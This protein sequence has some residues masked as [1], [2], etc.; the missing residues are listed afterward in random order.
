MKIFGSQGTRDNQLTWVAG[1]VEVLPVWLWPWDVQLRAIPDVVIHNVSLRPILNPEFIFREQR[2]EDGLKEIYVSGGGHVD[3][4]RLNQQGRLGATG[5]VDTPPIR[6]ESIP[7]YLQNPRLA[8]KLITQSIE[9]KT[10]I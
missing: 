10:L 8:M 7:T 3:V 5:V 2:W 6:N 4:Y 1:S 9:G